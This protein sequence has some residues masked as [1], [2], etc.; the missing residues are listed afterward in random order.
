[1]EIYKQ[2]LAAQ[3][4]YD[5]CVKPGCNECV[6]QRGECQCRIGVEKGGPCCGECTAAW[7]E[8]RGDVAGLDKEEVLRNLG[9]YRELYE[10]GPQGDDSSSLV[11]EH[12]HTATAAPDT[13]QHH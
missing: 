10:G 1:M 2:E 12:D 13:H 11:P 5:C 7:I 9:C 6:L 4:K 8:G 3:G